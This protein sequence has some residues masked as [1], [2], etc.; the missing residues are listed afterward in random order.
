MNAWG[1]TK[2]GGKNKKI[3]EKDRMGKD[4]KVK[5]QLT[6]NIID[7]LQNYFGIALRSNTGDFKK[8]QEAILASLFHIAS[9]ESED[10]HWRYCSK[11]TN[12]WCQYQRDTI[13]GTNSNTSW[14]VYVQNV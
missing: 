1:I 5:S 4:V 2:S 6:D 8:M 11:S 13:N 3:S 10:D 9:S 7:K 12:S 14:R